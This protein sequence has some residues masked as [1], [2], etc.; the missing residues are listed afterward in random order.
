MEKGARWW[1]VLRTDPKQ[2]FV[3][4]G[5]ALAAAMVLALAQP[6][7]GNTETPGAPAND[8]AEMSTAVQAT[9]SISGAVR[10]VGSP[11]EPAILQMAADPF[12]LTAHQGETVTAENVVVNDN[13]TLRWVFVYVRDPGAA[14][15]SASPPPPVELN[16]VACVYQPRVLGMQAGATIKITNSDT[17]LHNV[18]VQAASN[19][20]FNVAQ[21]IPGMSIERSFASPEVM[22][23]VKCDVHGWM[24][25]YVG[26]LPHLF[27]AVTGGDGAFDIS[28]LPPGDYVVEAWHETLGTR[29]LSVSVAAGAA[30][31]ADFS[32]GNER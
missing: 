18:N 21:P 29:T 26:V 1:R 7:G 32:F 13:G 6:V 31:S 27:F 19:P 16:Q 25:A 22:I 4:T 10:F 24:Q 28:G 9:G 8:R 12:C 15:R 2:L 3:S 14:G 30:A 11:P 17:T 20:S 23:P 5:A